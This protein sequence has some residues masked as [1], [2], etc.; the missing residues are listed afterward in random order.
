MYCN[1]IRIHDFNLPEKNAVTFILSSSAIVTIFFG[2][3][4]RCNQANSKI[5]INQS[6]DDIVDILPQPNFQYIHGHCNQIFHTI[7]AKI[8]LC[9]FFAKTFNFIQTS[10]LQRCVFSSSSWLPS[11]II[12]LCAHELRKI[13]SIPSNI[14]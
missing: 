1:R 11:S 8:C 3:N 13:I 2:S 5:S 7:Q 6:D 12:I 9:F 4:F 10:R 14:R